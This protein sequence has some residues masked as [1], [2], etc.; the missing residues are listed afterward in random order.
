MILLQ[1]ERWGSASP[2]LFLRIVAKT[3]GDEKAEAPMEAEREHR[4]AADGKVYNGSQK[5]D[6]MA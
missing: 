2:F 4:I 3:V 5:T 1:A 6:T